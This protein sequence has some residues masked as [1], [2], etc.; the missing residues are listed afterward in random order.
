MIS[1]AAG[2]ILHFNAVRLRVNGVGEL[3][4]RF[5]GMDDVLDK[6]LASVNMSNTPGRKPRVLTNFQNQRGYLELKTTEIHEVFRINR[7][8]IFTRELWTEYPG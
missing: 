7:I 3:K 6:N 1:S 8:E 5:I 4:L 2:S